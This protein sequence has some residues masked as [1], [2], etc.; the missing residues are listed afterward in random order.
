MASIS[1]SEP[2]LKNASLVSA[3]NSVAGLRLRLIILHHL[4]LPHFLLLLLFIIILLCPLTPLFL[5]T[6]RLCT[7]S[8]IDL[9][10]PLEVDMNP[11]TP[12][13]KASGRSLPT[14]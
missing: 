7:S 13:F 9:L 4:S 8:L 5:S 6:G 10:L 2:G 12:I 1:Q 3:S 11:D 14:C